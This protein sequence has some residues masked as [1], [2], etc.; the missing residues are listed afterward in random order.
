MARSNEVEEKAARGGACLAGWGTSL[1]VRRVREVAE[2]ALERVRPVS[3][4]DVD[5]C[6][7][8]AV[9]GEHLH[10]SRRGGRV[11]PRRLEDLAAGREDLTVRQAYQLRQADESAVGAHPREDATH[12][13]CPVV[14]VHSDAAHRLRRFR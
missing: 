8:G 9:P 7:V 12:E 10:R 2:L 5:V 14:C 11:R 1:E 4:V 13:P 3:V 6:V